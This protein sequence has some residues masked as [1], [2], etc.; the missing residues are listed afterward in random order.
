MGLRWCELLCELRPD[1][2][3][4]ISLD[5][6]AASVWETH[7]CGNGGRPSPAAPLAA[8]L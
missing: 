4:L 1:N 2:T 3:A 7:R 6:P 8:L 5:F